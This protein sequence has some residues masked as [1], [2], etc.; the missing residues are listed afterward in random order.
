M[1]DAAALVSFKI[2]EAFDVKHLVDGHLGAVAIS[3]GLVW[4]LGMPAA[5]CAILAMSFV[6][7]TH[8]VKKSAGRFI[9][10][11]PLRPVVGAAGIT[12]GAFAWKFLFT[13][14]S[15]GTGFIGGEMVPLFA[16]VGMVATFGAAANAPR[17][18]GK[19]CLVP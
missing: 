4:K 19:L 12:A 11:P 9:A 6:H 16:A 2:V 17:Y 1:T 15:L 14:V 13:T 3:F 5:V 7:A 10:W 18:E 8:F